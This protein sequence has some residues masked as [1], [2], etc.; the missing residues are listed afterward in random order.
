MDIP[1]LFVQ[2]CLFLLVYD[3]ASWQFLDYLGEINYL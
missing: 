2:L 1:L 3:T